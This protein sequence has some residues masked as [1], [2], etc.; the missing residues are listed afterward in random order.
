M[1]DLACRHYRVNALQTLTAERVINVKRPLPRLDIYGMSPL[2]FPGSARPVVA[3]D[4]TGR[5]HASTTRTRGT[6]LIVGLMLMLPVGLP[7][8]SNVAADTATTQA[9]ARSSSLPFD[10]PSVASLRSDPKLVFAHYWPPLPVSIDNQDPTKDYYARHYINNPY[11][12]NNKH[13]AYGGYLRDRPIQRPIR[14][15]SWRQEDLMVEVRQA[16]AGGLDGFALD[17]MQLPGDSDVNQVHTVRTMMKAAPAVDPGFKIMLMPDMGASVA[18]KSPEVLA[19]YLAELGASP[20]AYRLADGR[21]VIS[22]FKAEAHTASWWANFMNI[23][24][25]TH[26]MPVAFVPVFVGHESNYLTSFA[27]ISYGMSIW[28]SR[29]PAWNNPAE[30]FATSPKGRAAK[31]R[32]LGKLWMQPVS[33]QD[34]RPKGGIFDEAQNTTNLRNTWQLA[35]ETGA[36]WVQIPTW[37]DYTETAQIAPSWKNGPSLM[38][39]NSYYVT[40]FK[41]GVAPKVVRDTIYLTHRTQ[42]FAA[43]PTFAQTKLMAHRGGSPARDTV[44]ALTFLTAAATVTVTVGGVSVSCQAPAGAGT[45]TVPLRAGTVSATL[46]R[47]GVTVASVT[48]PHKVTAT[49]YVQ[50]L[51]YLAVSS[52]RVGTHTPVPV[53]TTP[54]P[55]PTTP[56]PV[57]TTPAPV[58]TTA[59]PVPTTPAPVPTTAAPVPTTAAP[60]PTTAAPVPT[61]PAPVPTTAAPIPTSPTA[62]QIQIAAAKAAAV[63]KATALRVAA[64]KAAA[65]KAAAKKAAAKKARAKAWAKAK[66]RPVLRYGKTGYSVRLVQR[67]LGVNATGWFGPV[68]RGKVRS[69]QRRNHVLVSGVVG[70]RTWLALR[71]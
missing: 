55:V 18:T 25:N 7:A 52:R 44:E 70:P 46:N 38:D 60:V 24:K 48:S 16:I 68:T 5:R 41:T 30:T 43:K 27:P 34:S 61:T 54:A 63:A 15:S 3:H 42:P 57:P 26:K 35:R 17:I 36:Q 31:I 8:A 21:L 28:G 65:K 58:P 10:L 62:E 47:S 23:M 64:A 66:A 1:T 22:P 37:N 9:D 49:P 6:T 71:V 67:R 20:S 19:A 11:G 14:G 53:P 69:F 4:A 50:D 51:Q 29:N 56:A 45:C 33:V 59:A 13:V 2:T 32:A 12:E 39:I 40:W